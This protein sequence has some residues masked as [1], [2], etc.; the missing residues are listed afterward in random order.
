MDVPADRL[1]MV[2]DNASVKVMF[3]KGDNQTAFLPEG[4]ALPGLLI[5]NC[6]SGYWNAMYEKNM[7]LRGRI[8]QA[9]GEVVVYLQMEQRGKVYTAVPQIAEAIGLP[10]KTKNY[11]DFP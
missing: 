5:Q 11:S 9:S 2:R 7:L 6:D 10:F 1:G 8:L 4:T 3:V